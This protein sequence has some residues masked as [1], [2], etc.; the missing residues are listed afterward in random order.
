MTLKQLEQAI[1]DA[2]ATGATDKTEVA[3]I[4]HGLRY[5]DGN[6]KAVLIRVD[7]SK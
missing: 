1:T 6:G 5:V 7:K 4:M 2:R 3:V